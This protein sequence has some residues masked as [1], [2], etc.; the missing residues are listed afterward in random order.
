MEDIILSW[1]K[2]LSEEYSGDTV[3]T[4]ECI[5]RKFFEWCKGDVNR[6]NIQ[7]Y[8]NHLKD[9]KKSTNYMYCFYS[10]AKTFC[11]YTGIGDIRD[12]YDTLPR[13][14]FKEYRYIDDEDLHKLLSVCTLSKEKAIVKLL[15]GCALRRNE[16]LGVTVE[17]FSGDGY[18]RVA[19]EKQ[20]DRIAKYDYV[21]IDDDVYEDVMK[22]VRG[23]G[24]KKGKIFSFSV[25]E[26]YGILRGLYKIAKIDYYP[27]KCFRHARATS[28][29]KHK[30]PVLDIKRF[31]RH[32]TLRPTMRYVHM[33]PVDIKDSIPKA[34]EDAD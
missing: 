7:R 28:L 21:P 11:G 25:S 29:A 26:L 3:R 30:V 16:L 13:L 2:W 14:E 10:A 6:V 9:T 18:L 8:I 23:T 32:R 20:R 1:K 5:F 4:Y 15:Y 31:M 22:Y 17:D 12:M 19:T 33:K 24:R 27:P 34:F